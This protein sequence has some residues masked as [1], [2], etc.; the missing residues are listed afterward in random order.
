MGYCFQVPVQANGTRASRVTFVSASFTLPPRIATTELY[1]AAKPPV[2]CA[3]GYLVKR[4][5]LKDTFVMC[6]TLIWVES[7]GVKNQSVASPIRQMVLCTLYVDF[8]RTLHAT[9]S[10]CWCNASIHAFELSLHYLMSCRGSLLTM[11]AKVPIVAGVI[12]E[13]A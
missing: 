10:G 12:Y 1:T 4:A 8:T 13:H 3:S 7:H 9:Y 6:T 5:I 11:E 2:I